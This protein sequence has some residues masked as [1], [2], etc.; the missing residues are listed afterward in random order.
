MTVSLKTLRERWVPHQHLTFPLPQP[1][2]LWSEGGLGVWISEGWGPP[3]PYP[4]VDHH[5]GN[6]NYGYRPVKG[7]VQAV[8]LTPEVEGWPE[9]AEFLEKLNAESSPIE[10]VGCEKGIFPSEV[11][12]LAVKLGSYVDVIFTERALNHG[13]DN[14]L[15]L[16][17][18]LASAVE[19]CEKW[20]ADISLVLQPHKRILGVTDPWGLMI[21]P[22]NYGRAEEEA[23]RFLGGTLSRLGDAVARL[24]RDFRFEE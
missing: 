22:Q 15:L 18:V 23:R 20:A 3:V 24:P 1:I 6:V 7:N 17:T 19:G 4:A 9:L 2:K 8:R 14:L 21:R 11:E 13:T 10:S 12:G 16:A 5:D